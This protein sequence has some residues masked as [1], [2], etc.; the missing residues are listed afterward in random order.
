MSIILNVVVNHLLHSRSKRGII[1]LPDIPNPLNNPAQF[2]NADFPAEE[3]LKITIVG[4]IVMGFFVNWLMKKVNRIDK[5]L[6][7]NYD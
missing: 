6:G 5:E 7:E 4:M 2:A 3:L 1:N